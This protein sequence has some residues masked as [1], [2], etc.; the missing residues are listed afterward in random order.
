[1]A[2]SFRRVLHVLGVGAVAVKLAE[3]ETATAT[4][5]SSSPTGQ[6]FSNNPFCRRNNCVN[7][8]TPG[9]DDM[10]RLEKM[11][12]QCPNQSE[13]LKYVDFC[14]PMMN[15]QTSLPTPSK[16]T[17][18]NLVV[19]AQDEA[20][21]TM[22][23]YHMAGLGYEAWEH[24][25]PSS[26]DDPCV[27]ATYQLV[28]YTYFPKAQAGCTNSS[29]TPYLRPCAGCCQN[30]L[31]ACN[32]E[33]CD[34]STSCV[35]SYNTGE[36]VANGSFL[37]QTGYYDS[38]GPSSLCTGS[39]SVGLRAPFGLLLALL[40]LHL[41]NECDSGE[42][43]QRQTPGGGTRGLSKIVLIAAFAA[44]ATCLQGCTT[45]TVPTHTVAN[46]RATTDYLVTNEYV[47]PGQTA[48]SAILNSC[49][50]VSNSS[51]VVC[52]GHGYCRP[53]SKNA[54]GGGASNN[55]GVTPLTFCVC[56]PEWADP[57]CRTKRKS[58]ITTFLLSTFFGF[59]GLDYFY[60]GYHLWGVTKLFTL[61][62]FGV[63]WLV[64]IV[65]SGTGPVYAY[66][67]RVN[68]D[69][70][71]WVFVVSITGLLLA[72]GFLASIESYLVF[73]NKK[74]A[75]VLRL[76]QSYDG[77]N[78]DGDSFAGVKYPG[79]PYAFNG[80]PAFGGWGQSIPLQHPNAGEP[81]VR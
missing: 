50:D 71:H 24:R 42:P 13:V 67:F 65:R 46:W 75:A 62:G 81:L 22:F 48:A 49:S 28:C 56:D 10:S 1:M 19:K 8:F 68:H 73:R 63:W 4:V 41:L 38:S 80:K 45:L 26:S 14:K 55:G 72:I 52:S 30:Y 59:L 78:A 40:G 32:V 58:Q 25:M 47:P 53:W 15:Y 64:D 60:L 12:W 17:P 31:T 79:P 37:I 39:G 51:T 76:Q 6:L 57:E 3:T 21:A 27:R 11:V 70:P 66:N 36:M 61:G 5:V 16:L 54:V 69:L 43:Q 2:S 34:D 23:F 20:A 74:R 7:P 9:L 44:C 35:F 18:I 29:Q 77:R 33:C